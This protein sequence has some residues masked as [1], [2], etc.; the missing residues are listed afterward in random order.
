M[1]ACVRV[2]A[3]VYVRERVIS[4][5]RCKFSDNLRAKYSYFTRERKNHGVKCEMCD[6]Y[7]YISVADQGVDEVDRHLVI[8]VLLNKHYIPKA[9][10]IFLM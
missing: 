8:G 1:C 10:E 3:C 2:R 9:A 4:K 7:T 5:R 6:C